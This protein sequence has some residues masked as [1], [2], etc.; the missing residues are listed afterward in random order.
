MPDLRERPPLFT[1]TEGIA[2]FL[3][4]GFLIGTSTAVNT[5]DILIQRLIP[6]T[7]FTGY[8][9]LGFGVVYVLP[10]IPWFKCIQNTLNKISVYVYP[11]VFGIAS[12]QVF[13][14][15]IAP[16]QNGILRWASIGFLVLIFV[17]IMFAPFGKV[18]NKARILLSLI[19]TYNGLAIVIVAVRVEN[20]LA[21]IQSPNVEPLVLL[22]I[23]FV[24]GIF[25][26]FQIGKK[27]EPK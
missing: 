27:D 5:T 19:L 24:C 20:P 22:L 23:S 11:M 18:T 4:G 17:L 26:N 21:L 14:I 9:L 3:S 8:I 2:F 13:Q 7:H 1:I 15:A 10:L 12:L 16:N 6:F 25:L